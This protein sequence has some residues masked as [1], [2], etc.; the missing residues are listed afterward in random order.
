MFQNQSTP[1]G[2]LRCWA[3]PIYH[4]IY[5]G[6]QG[7]NSNLRDFILS[8]ELQS[9]GIQTTNFG[10][11]NS[12]VDITLWNL[13]EMELLRMWINEAATALT[14]LV[15]IELEDLSKD[16]PEFVAE[17]WALVYRSGNYQNL[18][19]HHDSIWSGVYYVSTTDNEVRSGEI[20][21]LDPRWAARASGLHCHRITPEPGLLIVFPSWLQHHVYPVA[22]DGERIC[23]AFNVGMSHAK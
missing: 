9:D 20:E 5:D 8:K 19:F 18:H 11:W 15:S 7:F 16:L 10:A 21:F 3:T 1:N 4:R 14:R 2:I 13:K 12:G 23:I 22:G 17:C 6:Y